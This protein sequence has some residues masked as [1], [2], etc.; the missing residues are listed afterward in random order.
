MLEPRDRKPEQGQ[1]LALFAISLV[2]IV[3]MTGLVID[4]GMTFVQR[5]DQQNAADAAAMAGAYAYVN[6]DKSAV[7]DAARAA[8]AANGF[9]AGV[10]GTSVD[11]SW[12]DGSGGGVNVLVSIT[13]P[14]RNYFSS[15]LGFGS[16]DVSASA[17]ALG[18]LPN[19]ALGAMPLLFNSKTFPVSLG[20]MN[21]MAFSEPSVGDED[22]PQ[23]ASQFNWT[24]Y[25][26]A[27][28]GSCNG[29]SSTVEDLIHNEGQST[30]VTLD[31]EIGPLNAGSHTTLFSDLAGAVGLEFPVA[32]V[33]DD[34]EM[35]GW[36]MFHLTGSVGGETKEIRGYFVA[37]VNN[38]ALQV[39]QGVD[40]GGNFG[41]TVVRLTD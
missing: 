24:V 41:D 28:G 17:G 33:N 16:W 25:C 32:I 14:H 1:I 11:V 3:A 23:T 20:E 5:R 19:A 12:A 38:S 37:P 35:Q 26:T 30:V 39:V 8:A 21:E 34:G 10:D 31:D 29:D 40:L 4:G 13:K 9:A 22:V 36:A 27:S 6:G 2:A 7:G 15:I 18:G